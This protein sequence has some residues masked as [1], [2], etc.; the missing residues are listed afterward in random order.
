MMLSRKWPPIIFPMISI[1]IYDTWDPMV[2]SIFNQPG[3]TCFQGRRLS[4]ESRP[5]RLNP[6]TP[7]LVQDGLDRTKK[8]EGI[9]QLGS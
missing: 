2:K 5:D 1:D 4:P 8:Q 3:Q 9:R 6:V 7:Q